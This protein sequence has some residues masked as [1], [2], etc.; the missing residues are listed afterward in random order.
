M[1]RWRIIDTAEYEVT[2]ETREEAEAIFRD[3]APVLTPT[4]ESKVQFMGTDDLKIDEV[5]R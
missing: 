5:P 3:H 1:T 2:A 4:D